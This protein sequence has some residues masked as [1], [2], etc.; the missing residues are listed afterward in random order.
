[1]IVSDRKNGRQAPTKLRL[2]GK[3]ST[4]RKKKSESKTDEGLELIIDLEGGRFDRQKKMRFSHA[5]TIE[6]L[7]RREPAKRSLSAKRS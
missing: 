7:K 5:Q 3:R 2:K 1:M 4:G 6:R